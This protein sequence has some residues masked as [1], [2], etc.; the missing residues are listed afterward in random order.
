VG[1]RTAAAQVAQAEAV[2]AVDQ[3][4]GVVESFHGI[5]L[6]RAVASEPRRRVLAEVP[7]SF[8]DRGRAL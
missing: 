4:P 8:P 3:D 5:S 1:D 2:V 7:V 6:V